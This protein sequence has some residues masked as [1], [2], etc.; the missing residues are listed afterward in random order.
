M[1][2]NLSCE[3]SLGHMITYINRKYETINGTPIFALPDRQIR[4]IY[5]RMV[6]GPKKKDGPIE[7]QITMSEMFPDILQ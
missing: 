4:A 7:H 6:K 3:P 5:W 2:C 1:A